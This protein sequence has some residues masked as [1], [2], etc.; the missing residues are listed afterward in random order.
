LTPDWCRNTGEIRDVMQ[1]EWGHGLDD[2]DGD[3]PGYVSGLGDMATGEAAAD[4]IALFVD[5][6]S[7]IGQ[8]FYNRFSGPFITDPDTM[9]VAECDGVRNVD[10]KRAKRGTLTA[11]NVTQK[12]AAVTTSPYYIGPLLGQGHCEGE[13]WGQV[14]WHLVHGLSTGRK[15]GSATLDANKQHFTYAGDAIGNGPDGSANPAF[16][17]DAAWTILERLYF[18]SRPLVASYAPSRYQAMGAGAYDGFIVVDDEG[19]GLANGTPHAA[20]INDAYGHHEIEE[21]SPLAPRTPMVSDAK[22]CAPLAATTVTASQT[23]SAGE[24]SV[25][26][27][28]T[29]VAGAASYSVLRNERRNDVFLELGRVTGTSF[30]DV[31]V[32]NGVT[33]NYR[34][35][36]NSGAGCYSISGG[37]VKTV[38]V[39]MPRLIVRST[40]VTDSPKGNADGQL[41]AGER[42]QLY[43]ALGNTGLSGLT[44]AVGTLTSLT[45]GVTIT[46]G[47]PRTYGAIAV[48][49]TSS[50]SGAFTN[51]LAAEG[52]LC[53]TDIS[54]VLNVSSDQGCF[55][56]P[57]TLPVGG[58]SANC[59]VF[60]SAFAQPTSVAITSDKLGACGDGDNTPDPGETIQVSVAVNN[61]G[62]RTANNVSVTLSA[63]KP[64]L[65]IAN[66]TVSVGSVGPLGSETKTVTFSVVVGNAPHA[67]SAT[68]TA[69][70]TPSDAKKSLT[71]VVNRDLVR[72]NLAYDF[73]TDAQGWTASPNGWHRT[74]AP[75]TGNLTT[76]WQANYS[77]DHCDMLSSPALEL[78]SASALA[79]DVAYATEDDGHGYDGTDVQISIDGGQSWTTLEVT[80]GYPTTSAGTT[81]CIPKGAPMFA[82]AA[83]LMKRYNVDLSA[84]AGHVAQFRFRFVAD[85]LVDA[86]PIGVWLDNIT[87]SNITVS[88]PSATCH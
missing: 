28:W 71:T 42:A 44:N 29:P 66:P 76:V 35:Q 14:G 62:D 73:E 61:P 34:I 46:K 79:F 88:V 21:W 4:Y 3:D 53:G 10:E 7:C 15:Y 78:S 80:E 64:Y 63:D 69:T 45:P 52:S 56:V 81:N 87:A 85:P 55:A 9:A 77:A 6:D 24:P 16:D 18:E 22:N 72:R 49:G 11:T 65:T 41:D 19:D 59:T 43:V 33:Y 25:A 38:A 67:D 26:L 32:D 13:L 54:L 57:V 39:A 27:S 83:P 40:S 5:H 84:F 8:S 20:Y 68:F 17:R 23:I 47:N 48:G 12:C 82:G 50:G 86:Q 74:T 36:A 31:A 75:T 37:G 1:H 70:V 51:E 60:R 58:A 30:T 2:D